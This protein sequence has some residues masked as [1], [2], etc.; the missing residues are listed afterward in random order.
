MGR[1]RAYPTFH[2]Q[3]LSPLNAREALALWSAGFDTARIAAMLA[4]PESVVANGL[5]KILEK[6]RQ[7]RD[8]GSAA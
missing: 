7:D 4:L 1:T 2:Y 6:R 3:E 5:P 8:W